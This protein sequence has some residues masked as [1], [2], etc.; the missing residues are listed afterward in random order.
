M[1]DMTMTNTLPIIGIT[2]GDP[3]GIGPEILLKAL[4]HSEIRACC[5][6]VI[7][8][9]PYILLNTEKQLGLGLD[10][11]PIQDIGDCGFDH[12]RIDVIALSD[13]D[14]AGLLPGRPTAQTG[15]AMIRYITKAT[16]LSLAGKIQAMVTCPINKLAMKL[17]A[18]EFHGHT[19]LIATRTGTRDYVMMMSG[20]KLSVVL[21]TIHIP[22]SHV[23]E[24]IT[25]DMI[26][27]TIRVTGRA[28]KQNFGLSD[29]RIVVAALN[30]HAGEEGL[31]GTE[32]K[33]IITP[34]ILQAR[35]EGFAVSGPLPPDT[36]FFHAYNGDYDVV[37]CMYH[38][39][40][41]I[42][43]KLIH[44]SDGVNTTL[45]L[46]I[47]RTSVDHGTAYDIAGKGKANPNSLIE[48]IKLA[49]IQALHKKGI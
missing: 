2:M 18:S 8:G 14:P 30:P 21:V 35:K 37:V 20:K 6:P 43:F 5:R 19:E 7:L 47:I 16:D 48:A 3:V 23:T 12:D 39:Q 10:L 33:T 9:D 17:A 44:F 25:Q 45:G 22:L 31:F 40:G 29:P 36:V 34:A 1:K 24:S 15:E 41:L 42:P 13:L 11:N 4:T 32:E 28:L 38:D 46:P 26:L 27:K 49:S